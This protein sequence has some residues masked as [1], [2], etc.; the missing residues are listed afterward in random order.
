MPHS[1]TTDKDLVSR[2]ECCDSRAINA[3]LDGYSVRLI[4]Y[5]PKRF[6][7]VINRAR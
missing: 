5:K 7:K 2:A 3:F 1:S 4:R 6:L